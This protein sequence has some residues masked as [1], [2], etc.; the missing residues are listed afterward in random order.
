V[1]LPVPLLLARGLGDAEVA[2]MLV[3]T[4][5]RLLTIAPQPGGASRQV[6]GR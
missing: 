3:A 5:R 4:P 6:A 1:P 2:Q